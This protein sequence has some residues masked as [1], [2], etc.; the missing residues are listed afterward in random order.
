MCSSIPNSITP[1]HV[2]ANAEYIFPTNFEISLRESL[3]S[4]DI[5]SPYFNNSNYEPKLCGGDNPEC[6]FIIDNICVNVEVKTPN[7]SKRIVQEQAESLKIFP[8]ERIKKHKEIVQELGNI[9][10]E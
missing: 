6:N 2:L 4:K 8:A 5:L 3:H 1:P 10:N 9:I 7:Y